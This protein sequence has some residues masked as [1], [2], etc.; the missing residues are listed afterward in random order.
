MIYAKVVQVEDNAK[1]K[2]KIFHFALLRRRLT[3]QKVVQTEENT[4]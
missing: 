3:Y 4:K 2:H 1:K